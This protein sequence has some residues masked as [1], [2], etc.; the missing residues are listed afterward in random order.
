MKIAQREPI[1]KF[2]RDA[3]LG[4]PFAHLINQAAVR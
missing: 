1:A 3:S 2:A 4:E